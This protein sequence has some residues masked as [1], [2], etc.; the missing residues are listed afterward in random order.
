M[1]TDDALAQLAE[2]LTTPLQIEQHLGLAFEEGYLSHRTKARG[3][4]HH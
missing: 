4:R 1:I 3:N 2:R